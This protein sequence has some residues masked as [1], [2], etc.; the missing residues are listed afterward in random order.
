M[1]PFWGA[2]VRTSTY[3]FGRTQFSPQQHFI[4]FLT[5]EQAVFH[6]SCDPPLPFFLLPYSPSAWLPEG[7]DSLANDNLE[8]NFVAGTS[9]ASVWWCTHQHRSLWGLCGQHQRLAG[10]S[11]SGRRQQ[12]ACRGSACSVLGHHPWNLRVTDS[13]LPCTPRAPA[14]PPP[15]PPP[16]V[17]LEETRVGNA[18]GPVC[19]EPILFLAVMQTAPKIC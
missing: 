18:E 19:L 2:R 7:T 14:T 17:V 10:P 11:H 9:M 12:M 5:G 16:E 6:A 8:A 3:K 15:H 13:R 4:L 1:V